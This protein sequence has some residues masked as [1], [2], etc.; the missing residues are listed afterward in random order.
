MC[1]GTDTF[2]CIGR[3]TEL[4]SDAPVWSFEEAR[5]FRVLI[6][7]QVLL[8]VVHHSQYPHL[9]ITLAAVGRIIEGVLFFC[10]RVAQC[11]ELQ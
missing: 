10:L 8:P 5:Y 6:T 3:R 1:S 2:P 9:C 11:D 4:E 7:L